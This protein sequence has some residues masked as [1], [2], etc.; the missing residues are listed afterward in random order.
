MK[1][2]AAFYLKQLGFGPQD[3][4]TMIDMKRT[5]ARC[6]FE[7]SSSTGTTLT[8]TSPSRPSGFDDYTKRHLERVIRRDPFQIVDA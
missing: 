7:R 3:I 4:S 6:A 1:L 2:G 8:R 5:T